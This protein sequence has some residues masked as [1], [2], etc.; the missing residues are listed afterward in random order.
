MNYINN[1]KI[2]GEIYE[3]SYITKRRPPHFMRMFQGFG[4][5]KVVIDDLKEKGIKFVTIIYTNN[6]G[7][8]SRYRTPL[9]RSIDSD[10][11][12]TFEGDDLQKFVPVIDMELISRTDAIKAEI[13]GV[14]F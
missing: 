3:D 1:G 8:I 14:L 11:E 6:D 13:D 7:D 12:F 2:I 10:K 4:I 9:E 5:S